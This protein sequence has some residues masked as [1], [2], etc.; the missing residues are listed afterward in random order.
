MSFGSRFPPDFRKAQIERQLRPGTVIKL[1]R[2]MDDGQFHEKRYVVMHVDEHTITCVINSAISKFVLTR[3]A[4]LKC[5]VSMPCAAHPFMQHDSHVDC[6]RT[7]RFATVDV[8]SDLSSQTDWILGRITADMR[9]EIV[10]ALK[11][12][13]TLS[14]AEVEILCL[15][16][17]TIE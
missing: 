11:F 14:A 10:G 12:S 15:S 7:H 9:D 8:V 3:P 4:L 17:A 5:Q 13:E 6:S 1:Y 2:R 16:L